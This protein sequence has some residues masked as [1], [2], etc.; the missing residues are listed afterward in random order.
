MEKVVDLVCGR[1]VDPP[2]APF[3]SRP[4]G[5]AYYFCPVDGKKRFDL[6]P[7]IYMQKNAEAK[8]GT[9]KN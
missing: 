3:Q 5:R 6:H 4:E 1:E 2:D 9:A 8:Q 7:Q